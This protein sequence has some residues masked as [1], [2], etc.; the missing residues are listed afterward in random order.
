[1]EGGSLQVGGT[2]L[3]L[4]EA[5]R[6][7]LSPVRSSRIVELLSAPLGRAARHLGLEILAQGPQAVQ[8]QARQAANEGARV[9][10]CDAR[11]QSDLAILAEAV[12][13]LLPE[14]LLAG[15]A[16]LARE[17][18][19]RLGADRPP[20]AIVAAERTGPVLVIAGSRSQVTYGQV[21]C[22]I[23]RT[24]PARAEID[25]AAVEGSWNP[26]RRAVLA[27]ELLAE[28]RRD[29][30]RGAWLVTIGG[31]DGGGGARFHRR[32]ER[33]NALLG[34]LAL[35]ALQ[36]GPFTGLVLTGGDVAAS[37][38][39][40]L[41]AHGVR[42]GPEILPGIPLGAVLGGP[43]EGLGLVTKAG[44]FGPPEALVEAVATL[45]GGAKTHAGESK[46]SGKA[47]R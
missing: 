37:V 15:S 33:L 30:S 19:E 41:Q 45:A 38:L 42:L 1:M 31:A 8:A 11:E 40:S 4:S 2:P 44:A 28:L 25:A 14:A 9:L 34:E 10:I 5:A 47:I 7:G 13:P 22:L 23:Q 21:A 43:Y 24:L 46:R 20:A 32:S 29:A 27:D 12:L 35:R 3:H 6:D 17:L 39:E 26:A 36:S 16:G 18:A